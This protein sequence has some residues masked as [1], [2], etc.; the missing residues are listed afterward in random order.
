[1]AK[2]ND[3]DDER[4][5]ESEN[6]EFDLVEIEE[7]KTERKSVIVK[8]APPGHSK[9]N[10]KFINYYANFICEETVNPREVLL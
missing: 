2:K 5:R 9:V 10:I 6:E 1:M 7:K 3:E 8:I 4:I